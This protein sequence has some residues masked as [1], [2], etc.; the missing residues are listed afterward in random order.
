MSA[1][2]FQNFWQKFY[3]YF[4]LEQGKLKILKPYEHVQT[5]LI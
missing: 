1:D 3:N 4:S 2:G 5:E